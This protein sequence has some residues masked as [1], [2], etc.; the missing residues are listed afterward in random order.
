MTNSI[1]TRPMWLR[2][3]CCITVVIVFL[4]FGGKVWQSAAG[5][6]MANNFWNWPLHFQAAAVI[7]LTIVAVVGYRSA[8]QYYK[9]ARKGANL[10]RTFPLK[11]V[12][13]APAEECMFKLTVL[14]EKEAKKVID[15]VIN[16]TLKED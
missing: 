6:T 12:K 15:D 9:A 3:F 1:L 2:I 16:G 7:G 5:P 13:G 8:I 10:A 4:M 11:G 14:K